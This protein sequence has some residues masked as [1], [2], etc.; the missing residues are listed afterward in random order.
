ML[1]GKLVPVVSQAR[2]TT[3]TLT[4]ASTLTD[5]VLSDFQALLEHIFFLKPSDKT[6][7]SRHI[8][9][10]D[11]RRYRLSAAIR[12]RCVKVNG[13]DRQNFRRSFNQSIGE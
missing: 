9:V 5:C 2:V 8:V 1:M 11:D 13:R 12:H 4:T 6:C 7:A 10:E 3:R